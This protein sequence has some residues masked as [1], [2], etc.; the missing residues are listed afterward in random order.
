MIAEARVAG[1]GRASAFIAKTGIEKMKRK[2]VMA[3]TSSR[4]RCTTWVR[5]AFMPLH[6]ENGSDIYYNAITAKLKLTG[7]AVQQRLCFSDSQEFRLGRGPADRRRVPAS[8]SRFSP[9][10]GAGSK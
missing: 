8:R 3:F 9:T 5:R 2:V 6:Y 1:M 7:G 4:R 10:T